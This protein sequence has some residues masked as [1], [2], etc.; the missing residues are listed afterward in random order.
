MT[1]QPSVL[2]AAGHA[3][4]RLHPGFPL[5]LLLFLFFGEGWPLHRRPGSGVSKPPTF[6]DVHPGADT[7]RRGD[8]ARGQ[9]FERGA[10]KGN[11]AGFR[12]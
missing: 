8:R 9:G 7:E 11:A 5:P 4:G 1:G 6:G 2:L 10:F 12:D 3:Q